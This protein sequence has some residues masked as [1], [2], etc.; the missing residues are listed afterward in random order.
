MLFLKLVRDLRRSWLSALTIVLITALGIMLWTGF[1]GV[2]SNGTAITTEFYEGYGMPDLFVTGSGLTD[3]DL[4]MLRQN[5]AEEVM[6]RN[7]LDLT[8]PALDDAVLRV[9]GQTMPPALGRPVVLRGSLEMTDAPRSVVLDDD[10]MTANGLEVGD[11]LRLYH[12]E[13]YLDLTIVAGVRTP[14]NIYLLKDV[15]TMVPDHRTFGYA[16]V[17]DAALRGL[18]YGGAGN[19][20]SQIVLTTAD[21]AGMKELIDDRLAGKVSS[22][23]GRSE[24][25]S[26]SMVELEFTAMGAMV[27]VFPT[28]FFLIAALISFTSLKRLIDKERII[29]GTMK[30]LGVKSGAVLLHYVSYGLL[31]GVAAAVIGVPLGLLIPRAM[32]ELMDLFFSFQPYVLTV[33]YPTAAAAALAAVGVSV[34]AA[35]WACW[36]VLGLEASV[37][38]RPKSPRPG[39]KVLLEH[40]PR[41]WERLGDLQKVVMRN[42]LRNKDRLVMSIFGITCSCALLFIA[43]G[44][45]SSITALMDTVYESVARYDMKIYFRPGTGLDQMQRAAR[46]AG[47]AGGELIMETGGKVSGPAAQQKTASITVLPDDSQLMGIYEGRDLTVPLPADGCIL[48]DLLAKELG[49]GEGDQIWVN[50][51]GDKKV[52]PLTVRR[53]IVQN[54]GQ[55]IFVGRT[56]WRGTGEGFYPTAALARVGAEI[57]RTALQT[58]LQDFDFV[59]DAPYQDQLKASLEQEMELSNVSISVMILFAGIMAFVVLFDLGILNYYDRERELATLKVVGFTDREVRR[60]AFGE[61]RIFVAVGCLLGLILG[62]QGLGLILAMTQ[63][64]H[65]TFTKSVSAGTFLLSALTLFLFA[66]LTDRFLARYIRRIDLIACLKGVE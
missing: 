53:V 13:E 46:L 22:V 43:F 40:L 61:S 39:K 12:G 64:E 21:P 55:G 10:F 5:G 41:V 34:G 45:Q 59:L 19:V 27:G 17:N 31:F 33:N 16:L 7:V 49:V 26:A 36:G 57:D 51:M 52:F 48:S 60:M 35:L 28:V 9:Y 30:A 38:M 24:H 15:S 63:T 58:K 4:R 42:L 62:D 3:A 32:F 29:I 8:V 1:E 20:Y 65:Y 11:P 56:A 14:E 25:V 37:C 47:G 66:Y 44:M 50:F 18:L 6:G 23:T 54:F 2:A